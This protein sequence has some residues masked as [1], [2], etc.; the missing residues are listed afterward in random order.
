MLQMCFFFWYI[1]EGG[2]GLA[3]R[4]CSR[5]FPCR[6]GCAAAGRCVPC[7]NIR[8]F[9]ILSWHSGW[10]CSFLCWGFCSLKLGWAAPIPLPPHSAGACRLCCSSSASQTPGRCSL[11]PVLKSMSNVCAGGTD[12]G[13][14]KSVLPQNHRMV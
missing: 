10:G 13:V 5:A 14:I 7:M 9:T 11:V 3:S 12:F 6:W 2:R 8:L 4:F 1:F